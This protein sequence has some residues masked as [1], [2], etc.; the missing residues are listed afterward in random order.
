MAFF[1]G[2]GISEIGEEAAEV[3]SAEYRAQRTRSWSG[4]ERLIVWQK[5]QQLAVE[6]VAV[7]DS[8]A[9]RRST[10]AL[11]SQILRSATS[12][13]ANIAEGYGRYSEAAYRN[14]LSIARGSLAE[15]R[16]WVNLLLE[17]G[18]ITADRADRLT[19]GCEEILRLITA[20]MKP[21]KS[22]SKSVLREERESYV[23][24]PA[25]VELEGADYE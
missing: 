10:P 8:M 3:Q 13:P 24:E 18:H 22:A 7:V 2:P 14:H 4:F 23:I 5:A 6:V 20:T 1:V 17:T 19:G 25:E 12:V 16:S 15:T 21:M 11:A 9:V